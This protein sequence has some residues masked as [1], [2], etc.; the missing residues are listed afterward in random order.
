MSCYGLTMTRNRRR[1]KARTAVAV[2]WVLLEM[3][4]WYE[5]TYR[6]RAIDRSG[7]LVCA[8]LQ[9]VGVILGPSF[10]YVGHSPWVQP[11]PAVNTRHVRVLPVT[12]THCIPLTRETT[13]NCKRNGR[14][15]IQNQRFSGPIL[16][17][18]C[19]FNEK[20][21]SG[22]PILLQMSRGVYWTPMKNHRQMGRLIVQSHRPRLWEPGSLHRKNHFERKIH[23]F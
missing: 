8:H 4:D 19:I 22:W 2:L 3:K 13:C 14:F 10:A 23:R 6:Y 9:C 5:Y 7:P 1:W 18:L 15:S 21:Q 16:D 20:L 11:L 12:P 17:S